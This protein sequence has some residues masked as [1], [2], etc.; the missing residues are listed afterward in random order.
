[1]SLGAHEDAVLQEE[2]K[3]NLAEAQ[4]K[5]EEQFRK[6]KVNNKKEMDS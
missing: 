6:E 5:R 4:A 2:E 1:M 3:K